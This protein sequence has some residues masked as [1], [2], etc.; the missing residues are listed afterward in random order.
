MLNNLKNFETYINNIKSSSKEL[1]DSI[2]QTVNE[3]FNNKLKDFNYQEH[4]TG[5]LLGNVQ[6]GKTSHLFGIISDAA[7]KGFQ[8]FVLLTTDINYLYLQTYERAL[9]LLDTFNV[10][11]EH[12]FTRFNQIGLKKPALIILKKNTKILKKWRNILIASK[13]LNERPLFIIDDEGDAAS[14]NNL[15]NKDEQ[16]KINQHIESI[17]NNSTSSIYLQVTATPQSII[18]QSKLSDFRPK[19]IYYFSPGKK[20]L[21]GSF[22][23]NDIKS[24]VIKTIEDENHKLKD[25]DEDQYISKGLNDSIL[26]FLISASHILHKDN[27]GVCTLL[28]HPSNRIQD[29]KTVDIKIKEHLNCI[30]LAFEE[31]TIDDELKQIWADLQNTQPDLLD[32]D[33]SKDFIHYLL[34]EQDIKIMI[35]NSKSNIADINYHTGANIII[36]GNSLGRGITF[37]GLQTVYYSRRSKKPNADTYW[38]HCRMFGYDRIPGLMR[39]YIPDFLLKMF[40]ELNNSNQ[41]LINQIQKDKNIN[42]IHL[43]YP[44]GINP[45]RKQVI[46]QKNLIMIN[47]GVNYFPYF[48]KQKNTEL[49]DALLSE[50]DQT[51][52]YHEVDINIILK[53]LLLTESESLDDWN[54]KSFIKIIEAYLKENTKKKGI[55]I[56]RKDRD[57]KKNPRTLL[58]EDDRLLGDQFE[59]LSI[60]TMYRIK[61]SSDKGWN[62]IPL[63]IPNIKLPNDLVSYA[64]I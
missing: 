1:S 30:F 42:D 63:W 16:T 60:L 6:S 64:M 40:I 21:G 12:D 49:I 14:L 8:I 17:I 51:I 31:N 29:H 18:L 55:L 61:G 53:I 9:K 20:Y 46:D 39:I 26:T 58:S 34:K 10:C 47:G 50:Y 59:D 44:D 33:D 62:G 35:M 54:N 22:F 43:I 7:D 45:T 25:E 28:I 57:I 23:Y 4:I 19:F 3:I 37:P 11:N 56:V 36:G 27:N 13:L 24:Y 41:I 5:L 2:I 48:P 15:I 32:Y 52:P 38:Q